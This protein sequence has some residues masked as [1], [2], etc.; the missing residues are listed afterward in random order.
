M[1]GSTG[2]AVFSLIWINFSR[3]SRSKIFRVVITMNIHVLTYTTPHRKTYDVLCLLKARGY[4]SVSVWAVPMHYVKKYTPTVPHRP[5]GVPVRSQAYISRFGYAY[6]ELDSYAQIPPTGKE[7]LFLLCGGGILER[8][9]CAARTIINSHG[10]YIPYARGLDSYKWAIYLGLPV[11]VTTHI[12]GTELD[13][14][15]IIERKKVELLQTDTFHTLAQR[16]YELET[17]MLVDAIEKAGGEHIYIKGES[18]PFRRMPHALEAELYQKFE[19]YPY[20]SQRDL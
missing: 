11:G 18:E 8:D 10:G 15:E 6:K 16:A 13:A 19:A 3:I 17:C 9:F 12:I 1:S 14:G 20:K 4:D 5:D 2:M 7:D